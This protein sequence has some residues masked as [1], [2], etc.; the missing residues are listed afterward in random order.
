MMIWSNVDWSSD[1]IAAEYEKI[2]L[3]Y[4]DTGI[5]VQL[6]FFMFKK[7]LKNQ[8][9]CKNETIFLNKYD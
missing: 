2:R 9:N 7:K 8:K 6:L 3:Q 5:F 4:S 1:V